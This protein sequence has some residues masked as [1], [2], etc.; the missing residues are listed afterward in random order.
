MAGLG[1]YCGRVMLYRGLS[2]TDEP[3]T[4]NKLKW[5]AYYQLSCCYDRGLTKTELCVF[6]AHLLVSLVGGERR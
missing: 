3:K 6:R 1:V 5:T 4:N 2:H